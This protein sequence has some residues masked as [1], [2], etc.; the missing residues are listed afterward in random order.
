MRKLFF[1]RPFGE[2]P[3]RVLPTVEV[4]GQIFVISATG[5]ELSRSWPRLFH[6][7]DPF[8]W[9]WSMRALDIQVLGIEYHVLRRIEKVV[10][11]DGLLPND[12][13]EETAAPSRF[14]DWFSGSIMPDGTLFGTLHSDRTSVRLRNEE[15]KL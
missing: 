7:F 10:T 14:P 15:F 13:P 3:S 11:S 1:G 12:V 4:G 8:F 5:W 2:F 9:P 6:E